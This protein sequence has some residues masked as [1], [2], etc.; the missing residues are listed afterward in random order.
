M[1][2]GKSTKASGSLTV[3]MV[4]SYQDGTINLT[5]ADPNEDV[6]ISI[7]RPGGG[8]QIIE[9]QTDGTGA[10]SATFVPTGP[11]TYRVY[12]TSPEHTDMVADAVD[13]VL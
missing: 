8:T 12:V 9:A 13:A 2:K 6:L 10:A 5:G 3:Q 1:T 7:D 4:G 11:G